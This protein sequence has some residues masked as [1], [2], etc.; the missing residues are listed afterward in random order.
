M[1]DDERRAAAENSTEPTKDLE[2]LP[3]SAADKRE[4]DRAA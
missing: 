3:W 4:V 2:P 1:R